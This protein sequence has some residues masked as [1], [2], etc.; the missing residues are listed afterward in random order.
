MNIKRASGFCLLALFCFFTAG[1]FTLEQEIFLNADGS[2]ELVLHISLPDFPEEMRSAPM[3]PKKT[4]EEGLEGFKKNLMTGLPA[5]I[6]VKEVKEVKQNGAHGFYAIF[7]FKDIKDVEAVLASFGK[8][9]VKEGEMA[10]DSEWTLQLSKQGA[11]TVFTEKFFADMSEKKQEKPAAA[12]DKK[13][14]E[15]SKELEEQLKPLILSMI[16]MR[17]VLHAPAQISESNADIVL[18]GR[19]AVWDASLVTF[20]KNKKPIEMRV[21][22]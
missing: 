21:V 10:S 22:F 16:K 6:K 17:F 9:S 19:T 3:G 2:G 5:T 15:G 4:P 20:L 13:A 12:Q 14:S 8:S 7:Q 11:K 1:C 18:N